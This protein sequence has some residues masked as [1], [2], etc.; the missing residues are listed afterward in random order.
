MKKSML[1]FG[2]L[3]IVSQI[4]SAQW[5]QIGPYSSS[6]SGRAITKSGTTYFSGS[7]GFS[8]YRSLDGV[9]WSL[10][11]SSINTTTIRALTVSGTTI[12]A[13]IDG[14]S[15]IYKSTNNGDSWSVSNSGL[16]EFFIR[17]MLTIGSTVLARGSSG[18]IFRT[19]NDGVSW[20]NVFPGSSFMTKNN[21]IAYAVKVD[22]LFSSSNEG[23][24]WE[25]VG[26][27]FPESYGT[28]SISDTYWL[29]K[30]SKSIYRSSDQGSTWTQ[31]WNN[32]SDVY[33]VFQSGSTFYM[34]YFFGFRKS[35]N[36]GSTWTDVTP[37]SEFPGTSIWGIY[38]DESEVLVNYG[39]GIF[40]TTN[41]AVSWSQMGINFTTTNAFAQTDSTLF[42]A[43][44]G[45]GVLRTSTMG[46][47][48]IKRNTGLGSTN[49]NTILHYQSYLFSGLDG[50]GVYRS[51]NAGDNWTAVNTGLT[52]LTIYSL[53]GDESLLFVGTA[54]GLFKTDDY[55]SNWTLTNTGLTN[56]IIR[57]IL[58]INDT[59]MYVGTNGGV[60]RSVDHGENW[61]ESNTGITNNN[62]RALHLMGTNLYAATNGGGVFRSTDYGNS[63]TVVNT[64]LPTLY[65]RALT[66]YGTNLFV[67]I[68]GEGVYASNNN[69]TSWMNA[70][71]DIFHK[72]V[73]AFTQD[74]YGNILAGSESGGV[75]ITP[76][77]TLP[78]ELSA[79]SVSNLG[80]SVVL[81][82]STITETNNYGF[83]IESLYQ[84]Q[85]DNQLSTWSKVGFVAGKGTTTEIQ[86]YSFI[87]K[88]VS[89]GTVSYRLKQIDFDGKF[90]Y[91]SVQTL[92]LTPATFTLLGNYP[93]PFNPTTMINFQ[94]SYQSQITVTVFDVLGRQV[95]ILLNEEK[96]A[97]S[98]HLSFD[99]NQ[100]SSG[101]YFYQ[102][103]AGNEIKTGKMLLS[104]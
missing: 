55:G 95:S 41:H 21:S 40:R 19:T 1:I 84:R 12:F 73:L 72:R 86:T 102:V 5:E 7:T 81:N 31:V 93:N 98:Y 88:S 33:H 87:D 10:M 24:T 44:T 22:S 91:S 62:I 30:S 47:S 43:T 27:V 104:K 75:Y 58:I 101:L 4:V 34:A 68:F 11:T 52:S 97:G 17:D 61:A 74:N 76:G 8:F 37:G 25:N 23:E 29:Y 13:G 2:L 96:P 39:Y 15:G 16:T 57:T 56:N 20:S 48:W 9:N 59:L 63:W 14:G 83:E 42:I 6:A 82:W 79:F 85:G 78:V 66:S 100:L 99:A 60:F 64:G 92:E 45:N 65:A 35:I 28:I 54:N 38:Y 46:E 49:A 50:H 89:G 67:G 26:I 103:K 71:P 53:A 70:S 51:S 18:A 90:T 77:A 32:V 69:G 3:M 80:N 36:Q 94:T